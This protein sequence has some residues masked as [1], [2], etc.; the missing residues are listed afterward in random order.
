MIILHPEANYVGLELPDGHIG[1]Y[2][3][4]CEAATKFVIP[5]GSLL[6]TQKVIL[7]RRLALSLQA[8][9]IN[10]IFSDLSNTSKIYLCRVHCP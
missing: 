4:S 10:V 3:G 7:G 9:S 6:R 1:C 5:I 2:W 8:M